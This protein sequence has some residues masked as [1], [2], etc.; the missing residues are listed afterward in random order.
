MV[1]KVRCL[2]GNTLKIIAAVTMLIDHIGLFLFP[3]VSLTE[4][5]PVWFEME[6][7]LPYCVKK[8]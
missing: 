5:E 8:A 7:S 3:K 4:I 2:N 1:D 6:N